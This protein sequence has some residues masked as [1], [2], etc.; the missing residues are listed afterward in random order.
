ML[1]SLL[2]GVVLGFA[3]AKLLVG[4]AASIVVA[5][6]I[7]GLVV[8]AYYAIRRRARPRREQWGRGT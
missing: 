4:A 5:L 7:V 2:V 3:L 8:F 1:V 6:I